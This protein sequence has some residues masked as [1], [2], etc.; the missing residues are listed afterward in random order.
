MLPKST[1]KSVVLSIIIARV[2]YF[3]LNPCQWREQGHIKSQPVSCLATKPEL[4]NRGG[5]HTKV[6]TRNICHLDVCG[7][8]HLLDQY[9]I[10]GTFDCFF[11]ILVNIQVKFDCKLKHVMANITNLLLVLL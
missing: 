10:C 5:I 8:V 1:N 7:W 11:T 3:L 2:N 6:A 4:R 9:F